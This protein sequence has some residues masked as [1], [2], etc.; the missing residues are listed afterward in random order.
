M[1]RDWINSLIVAIGECWC[2]H[3]VLRTLEILLGVS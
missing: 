1:R 2:A 3:C